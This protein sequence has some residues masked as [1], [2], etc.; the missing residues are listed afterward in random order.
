MPQGNPFYDYGITPGASIA[1]P[2][3]VESLIR[4]PPTVNPDQLVP[5][6]NPIAEY[7]LDGSV[8]YNGMIIHVWYWPV[9]LI[10][11]FQ[12]LMTWVYGGYTTGSLSASIKTRND[13]ESFSKYNCQAIRPLI[14]QDYQRANK[15]YYRD[16]R[17]QFRALVSYV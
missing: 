10:A 5:S 2:R 3:N 7:T 14:G 11:D 13:Q 4:H 8:Q 6:V 16:L 9:I 1:N 12:T 17:W 15:L